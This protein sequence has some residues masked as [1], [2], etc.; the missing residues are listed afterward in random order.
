[1]AREIEFLFDTGSPNAYLVHR[2][3]PAAVAGGKVAFRY[4]PVL[5][6]G[7]FKAIGNQS[8]MAAYGHIGA[9][10]AYDR[11]EMQRFMAA[12]GI[13]N[14]VMN[15]HFPVNTLLM[16]RG[17]VAAQELGCARAYNDAMFKGMWEQGLKL[18]LPDVWDRALTAVGLPAGQ[19]ADLAA[20]PAVKARLV[21]NTEAA[22]ARGAF[23]SPT[24]F[25]GSEMWFGKER[26]RDAVE[27]AGG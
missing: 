26:L 5:L 4:V 8:P 13:T 7:I 17:A 10:V 27:A 15:P 25:L 3:I 16:M 21:A 22:V 14:F 1:M 12:H 6:G 24:F 20:D 2:A 19:L 9:K 23:G 18:D 11:L